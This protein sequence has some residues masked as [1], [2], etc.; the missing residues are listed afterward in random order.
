MLKVLGRIEKNTVKDWCH[1]I[2]RIVEFAKQFSKP[3]IVMENL[4]GMRKSID[5]KGM[6]RRLHKIPYAIQNFIEYKALWDGRLVERVNPRNTS[7][8][9]LYRGRGVRRKRLFKCSYGLQ[10][11]ADRVA[12]L[13]VALREYTYLKENVLPLKRLPSLK[14]VR[15]VASGLV[16]SP[17]PAVVACLSGGSHP[18]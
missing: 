5:Y 12:S 16:N 2:S 14:K 18:F 8:R 13:N 9:C 4:N 15:W 6:N 17:T 11:H 10:D 7:H 1:K 3:I